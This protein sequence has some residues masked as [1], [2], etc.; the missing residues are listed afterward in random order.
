MQC[1]RA[2]DKQRSCARPQTSWKLVAGTVWQEQLDNSLKV[3]TQNSVTWCTRQCLPF[4]SAVCLIS[5][6][7]RSLLFALRR[8][9]NRHHARAAPIACVHSWLLLSNCSLLAVTWLFRDG[10]KKPRTPG[11]KAMRCDT[12]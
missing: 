1:K 2:I 5:R 12:M 9:S 11:D 4:S 8:R 7:V 10:E 6:T 3:V